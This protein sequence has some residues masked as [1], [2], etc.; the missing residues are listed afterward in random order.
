MTNELQ[1]W[2]KALFVSAVFFGVAFAYLIIPSG[3]IEL[4]YI[5]KIAGAVAI[6][7]GGFTLLIGSFSRKW[8]SWV[9]FM[10]VR[11]HLGLIA[12]AFA[13]IH[14]VLSLFFLPSRFNL[15]WYVKEWVPVLFGVVAIVIWIYLALISRN[16]SIKQM[17]ADKWKQHQQWGG[18]IA[19]ALLFFHIAVMKWGSWSEWIM[20]KSRIP[21]YQKY[22]YYVPLNLIVTL[23]IIAVIVYRL[24]RYFQSKK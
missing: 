11:R 8:K 17:G 3:H 18:R 16:T 23:F 9:Q 6:L 2:I 1:K 13:A 4:F 5:N 19:F 12:F 22:P 20:R 10:T 14:L 24:V 15:E 7:I 21:V